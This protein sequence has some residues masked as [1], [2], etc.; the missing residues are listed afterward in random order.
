MAHPHRGSRE[1]LAS[2]AGH[3]RLFFALW[4]Q[5]DVRAALH[6]RARALQAECGGRATPAARIHLTLV[7][8]GDVPEARITDLCRAGDSVTA[9]GFGMNVGVAGYWRHNRIVWSGP[10][11]CPEALGT[12]VA[13]LSSALAQHGF[14]YD[15][16]TYAPHITL[17]RDARCAPQMRPMKVIPWIIS[18]F[19]L[20]QSVRSDRALVYKVLRHWP[21][22]VDIQ[23]SQRVAPRP[24]DD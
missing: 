10:Q 14:H 17:L 11:Q 18:G 9:P 4:P 6:A 2:A 21:L 5:D 8:L 19:V 23:T 15:Q 24:Q 7:F 1:G 22:G 20:V 12:L 3:A 13:E 16:R